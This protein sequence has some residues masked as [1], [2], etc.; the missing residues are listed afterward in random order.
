[1]YCVKKLLSLKLKP[2]VCI[3]VFVGTENF[4]SPF[5]VMECP[6][7]INIKICVCLY[8]QIITAT[9]PW[10]TVFN[11]C[12]LALFYFSGDPSKI[13]I[14]LLYLDLLIYLLFS[15]EAF[16]F[17]FPYLFTL[18]YFSVLLFIFSC[19]S[20]NFVFICETSF[21]P[22]TIFIPISILSQFL[23]HSPPLCNNSLR[24]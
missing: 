1:M 7:N 17:F 15:L 9:S 19:I 3:G 6:S 4:E 13:R 18:D 8:F 5:Q 11:I 14:L 10:H 16:C 24:C 21:F 12:A 23:S 20:S 22:T 2:K